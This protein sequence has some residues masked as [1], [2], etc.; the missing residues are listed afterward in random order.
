MG[1]V[2][3]VVSGFRVQGFRA[4]GLEGYFLGVYIYIYI[5]GFRV[6]FRVR[7]SEFGKRD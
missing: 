5:K 7:G 1:L 6:Y 4:S 3:G 2:L